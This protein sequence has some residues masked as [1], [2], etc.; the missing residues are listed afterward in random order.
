MSHYRA[1]FGALNTLVRIDR[2]GQSLHLQS[3]TRESQSLCIGR[4]LRRHQMEKEQ[5]IH[6]SFFD[7]ENFV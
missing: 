2:F 7:I 4:E 3:F 5:H 1:A 6:K